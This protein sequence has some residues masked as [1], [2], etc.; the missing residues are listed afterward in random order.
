[1]SETHCRVYVRCK[2][3]LDRPLWRAD[4]HCLIGTEE[5]TTEHAFTGVLHEGVSHIELHEQTIAPRIQ[6]LLQR[7]QSSISVLSYGPSCSGKSHTVFGTAGQTRQRNE[8]RGVIYRCG[9]QLLSGLDNN[10]ALAVSFIQVFADGRVADLFDSRK[11]S[12]EVDAS[13]SWPSSATQQRVG[14]C[15]ELLRLIEKG[16]LIRNATGCVKEPQRKLGVSSIK[17][18]PLQQYRPHAS[19]ALFRFIVHRESSADHAAVSTLSVVDLA[20]RSVDTPSTDS[21]V[22]ALNTLL[23]TLA[24]GHVV[25]EQPNTSLTKLLA[26]SF[27]GYCDTLVIAN[28]SLGSRQTECHLQLLSQVKQIKN[29]KTKKILIPLSKSDLLSTQSDTFSIKAKSP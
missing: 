9:E 12:M 2:P 15:Q 27:G 24:S 28:L 25:A 5:Q 6:A 13:E 7:E 14:T 11:R 3:S 20:G 29:S 23:H 21:G 26:P 4:S 19:H 17:P 1:M 10:G 16:Y 18:L 8:A 22:E